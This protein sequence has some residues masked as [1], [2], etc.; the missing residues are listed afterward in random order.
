MQCTTASCCS[1]VSHAD[2]L[3]HHGPQA[4]AGQALMHNASVLLGDG[5]VLRIQE[6]IKPLCSCTQAVPKPQVSDV[7]FAQVQMCLL[8][9]L[10]CLDDP[11]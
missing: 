7:L 8:L 6:C 10:S 9:L 4:A 3:W 5:H 1:V 2:V 11:S